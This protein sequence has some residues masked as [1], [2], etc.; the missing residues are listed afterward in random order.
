MSLLFVFLILVT[1]FSTSNNIGHSDSTIPLLFNGINP[2]MP[3]DTTHHPVAS[4][5]TAHDFHLPYA[6]NEPAQRHELPKI[7]NEISGLSLTPGNDELLTAIQDENGIL[8]YINKQ[9]GEVERELTF[10][11][12][13]DYE[14]VE[15]VGESVYVI[16]STG[17]IYEVKDLDQT[18]PYVLKHKF[19][20]SKE[21][22]VEGL[23][24]DA[25]NDRL[26]I[27]CKGLA[28]TGESFEK[29]KFKKAIFS[30][31]LSDKS[32]DILPT[33]VITLESIQTY[34]GQCKATKYH[35]KLTGYF[36]PDVENLIFSPSAIA[37]HPITGHLYMTSSAK[38]IMMV[39]DVG[40]RIL[41]LE[42]MDKSVHPQPEGLAFDADGTLYISNEGKKEGNGTVLR[43]EY[44]PERGH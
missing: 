38:K 3:S 14:G 28:A 40:G 6:L 25:A 37:V 32:M 17:T 7:L 11:K 26:L 36:N 35:D 20:L 18:P 23:C 33:Y 29:A 24:Y 19:F 16:K 21:N 2:D 10:Y 9:T 34:L 42:K 4:E 44:Q 27:A 15:V 41:H 12:D 13:G 31:N 5:A 43:F 22:D 30:F 1:P 8:F 39:I